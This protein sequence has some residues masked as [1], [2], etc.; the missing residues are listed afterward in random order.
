MITGKF[1]GG[2]AFS[3]APAKVDCPTGSVKTFTNTSIDIPAGVNIIK[4]ELTDPI[5]RKFKDYKTNQLY[6]YVKI[7]GRSLKFSL[8]L[9]TNED[10]FGGIPPVEAIALFFTN[11]LFDVYESKPEHKLLGYDHII[12]S[13]QSVAI[14][15]SWAPEINKQKPTY[16]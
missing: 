16:S 10:P 3:A 9:F 8:N 6:T 12:A 13:R 7:S 14:T 4:L 1:M 11:N 2:V 15:I 5:Y